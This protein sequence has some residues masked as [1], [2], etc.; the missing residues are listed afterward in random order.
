M[1]RVSLVSC[2][3]P[4]EPTVPALRHISPPSTC[5][6]SA[7]KSPGSRYD[8]KC[9]GAG[10]A[11]C[12]VEHGFRNYASSWPRPSILSF[13]IIS[14]DG[15]R[16]RKQ[17]LTLTSKERFDAFFSTAMPHSVCRRRSN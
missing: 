5:P 9:Q 16:L 2:Y 13:R 7:T 12:I 1:R 15:Y 6:S 3:F 17:G 8:L 14:S 11:V 4:P 10:P